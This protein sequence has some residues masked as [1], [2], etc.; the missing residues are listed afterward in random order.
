M[1]IIA[2]SKAEAD[3][4]LEGLRRERGFEGHNQANPTLVSMLDNA[5]DLS[6]IS[7]RAAEVQ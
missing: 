7:E 2:A 1:D 5:L 6:A 4:Q 3:I